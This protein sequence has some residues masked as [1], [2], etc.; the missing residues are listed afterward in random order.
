MPATLCA[1]EPAPAVL[2]L[3]TN[4]QK[5]QL[6]IWINEC[7][8]LINL[9]LID[10]PST[11]AESSGRMKLTVGP[12]SRNQESFILISTTLTVSG[13]RLRAFSHYAIKQ[14]YKSS[15]EQLSKC[16]QDWKLPSLW[17]S[18]NLS[19]TSTDSHRLKLWDFR[20][21]LCKY[22]L[23]RH[24]IVPPVIWTLLLFKKKLDYHQTKIG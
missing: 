15:Y 20:C 7:S 10:Y 14:N 13:S 3:T 11:V 9:Q 4:W 19:G 16:S 21:Y 2:F 17:H 1:K 23:S 5:K 24:C 6:I 12:V 18:N 22:T 8:I